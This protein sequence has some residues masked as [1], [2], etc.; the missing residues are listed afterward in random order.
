MKPKSAFFLATIAVFLVTLACAIRQ[1]PPVTD[2]IPLPEQTSTPTPEP[3]LT[4][5]EAPTGPC[6]N[7]FYP[8]V[9]GY[10]WI[11]QTDDGNDATD[12]V[13]KVG[14]TVS[15]VE[16]VRAQIDMLDLATG[17]ITHT[18]AECEEGAIK[19]YPLLTLGTLFGSVLTG[20]MNVEYVSG[21]FMPAE[22]DLAAANWVTTWS[23]DYKAN[24]T[25]AYTDE[26]ETTTLTISD[27][28]V[29]LEWSLVGP[30]SVTVEAGNFKDAYKVTRK[31]TI[32][33]SLEVEEMNVQAKLIVNTDQWYAA[34]V[35][36]LKSEVESA[37]LGYMDSTFPVQAKNRVE[38]MEFRR[39][40]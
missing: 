1:A 8:F 4:Q 3:Q 10:Q 20:E 32:D 38:L 11:Y 28:P 15:S 26:G 39:G 9:P 40:E 23:G 36:L 7:V 5:T 21:V 25:F 17:V 6:M 12:D 34:G 2:V 24:G 18:T 33:V 31:A 22:S 30:E 13:T 37:S 14:L 29:H 19:N 27:S 16:G 35:G